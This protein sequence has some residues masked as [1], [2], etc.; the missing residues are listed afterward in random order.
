[1]AAPKVFARRLRRRAE[2]LERQ[3]P[4]ILVRKAG[5]AILS[6]VIQATPVDEGRARSNWLVGINAPR[7]E[8]VDAFNPGSDGSTGGA[9]ARA[10]QASGSQVIAAVSGDDDL[11][12]SNNLPYINALADGSSPQAPAGWVE[13]VIDAVAAEIDDNPNLLGAGRS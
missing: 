8:E 11:W 12:L 6:G 10:A 4:D 13:D 1:M 2:F 9:N 5:L 7:R 3:A